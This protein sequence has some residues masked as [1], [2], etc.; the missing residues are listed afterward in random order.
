[1]FGKKR[2]EFSYMEQYKLVSAFRA[3]ICKRLR[4]PGIDSASLCSMTGR[5]GRRTGPPGWESIPGLLKRFTNS[6][7]SPTC[8]YAFALFIVKMATVADELSH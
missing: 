8:I 7:C 6:G 3:R 5:E 4:S 2:V 1:M